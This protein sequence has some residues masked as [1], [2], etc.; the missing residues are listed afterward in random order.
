MSENNAVEPTLDND[1]MDDEPS[2]GLDI[3]KII[4]G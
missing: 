1:D 2:G 4:A 3:K